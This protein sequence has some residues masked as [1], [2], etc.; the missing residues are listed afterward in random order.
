M[1]SSSMSTLRTFAALALL[2][3]LAACQDQAVSAIAKPER[4][5]PVQRVALESEN[6]SREFCRCRART[7]RE[8][9][10]GFRVAGKIT[11]R[12]VNVGDLVHAPATSSHGSSPGPEPE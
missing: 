10:L 11:E 9:D 12:I 3:L 4:P 2:P 5:V 7:V 6:A 8:T 1:P